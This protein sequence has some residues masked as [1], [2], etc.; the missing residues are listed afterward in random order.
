MSKTYR[1]SDKAFLKGMARF[2]RKGR[3]KKR[4]NKTC[5]VDANLV[6]DRDMLT[7]AQAK[8]SHNRWIQR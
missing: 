3:K 2:N 1:G 8:S 6:Y 5:L 4:D 7:M